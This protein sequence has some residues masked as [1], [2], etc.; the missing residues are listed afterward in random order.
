M[1]FVLGVLTGTL[2]LGLVTAPALASGPIEGRAGIVRVQADSGTDGQGDDPQ[3]EAGRGGTQSPPGARRNDDDSGD[4]GA[5]EDVDPSP[6][7]RDPP[8]CTYQQG[9]L[10]LIV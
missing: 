4:A 1:R 6:N 2:V 9:P 10:E 3:A 8:G 5:D 7:D